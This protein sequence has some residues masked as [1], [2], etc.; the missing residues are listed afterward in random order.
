MDGSQ[1]KTSD[2]Q[3]ISFQ[4][5]PSINHEGN[6]GQAQLDVNTSSHQGFNNLSN[7]PTGIGI[8][9]DLQ[10]MPD[11]SEA[12]SHSFWTIEYYQKFFNVK[13][14]DVVERIKRSMFPHGSDNYLISHIRPNPDLYGPFWICVTLI[15]SIAISGNLADYLHTANS[16]KYHWRYEFHI[17]SYAA[18]CI[19]LYAWLL[20]L[21]LWGAMKWTTS[22]RNTEE[23]L[24]ESYATPGLLELLCLYGYSLAIYIP[25]AFLW[26]I[27]FEWLQWSLVALATFLSGGVLLRSLL[28]LISGRYRIMYIVIILGMHLLLA[29]G[30]MRYFFHAPS[31][32]F[33]IEHM[34]A[35][36]HTIATG[37][38]S[39]NNSG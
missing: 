29:T 15:F 34:E 37:N 32:P 35:T 13:T 1:S 8:I 24:I 9:E 17:V 25:V 38:D 36:I 7:D 3:F 16:G 5:F 30:F 22:S 6:I 33:P 18:T 14:D 20:P 23:E 11:K 4:D 26:T 21:T 27:Q 39:R 19:F 10:G 2:S 28:P 12:A 31:K